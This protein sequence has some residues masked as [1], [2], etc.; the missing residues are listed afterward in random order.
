MKGEESERVACRRGMKKN[1][2]KGQKPRT[3]LFPRL[4]RARASPTL[5]RTRFTRLTLMVWTGILTRERETFRRVRVRQ[6]GAA[7]RSCAMSRPHVA[8]PRLCGPRPGPAARARHLLTLQDGNRTAIT[9]PPSLTERTPDSPPLHT[10]QKRTQA[11]PTRP[12]LGDA[13]NVQAAPSLTDSLAAATRAMLGKVT[14]QAVQAAPED[15]S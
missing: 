8:P 11:D 1:G 3:R 12:P 5:T 13:S 14:A 10:P 4:A 2:E 7:R 9:C 6:A 15:V